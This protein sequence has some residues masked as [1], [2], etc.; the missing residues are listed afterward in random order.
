MSFRLLVSFLVGAAFFT[1][2]P[3][4]A[5][6]VVLQTEE[7]PRF[8]L[9]LGAGVVAGAV[10][11]LIIG[12]ARGMLLVLACALV[13]AS[14]YVFLYAVPMYFERWDWLF[15]W[16]AFLLFALAYS[17][18]PAAVGVTLAVLAS[19]LLAR[20]RRAVHQS[21]RVP[22]PEADVPAS[23]PPQ[24][25]PMVAT[26]EGVGASPARRRRRDRAVRLLIGAIILGGIM[27]FVSTLV[28][29]VAVLGGTVADNIGLAVASALQGLVSGAIYAMLVMLLGGLVVYLRDRDGHGS[30]N[31]R[32]TFLQAALSW[33]VLLIAAGLVFLNS[34]YFPVASLLQEIFVIT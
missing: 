25:P 9:G 22:T 14:L 32:I 31:T 23:P 5:P 33:Q 28:T 24:R 20:R 4:Y 7:M 6:F 21:A 29:N 15:V 13:G 27:W 30:A 12:P 19:S 34:L 10:L 26:G 18:L 3:I 8:L 16:P 17:V 2:L 11:T 1:I